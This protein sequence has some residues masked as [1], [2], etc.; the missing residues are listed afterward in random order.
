M[1]LINN[2]KKRLS[3]SHFCDN[4]SLNYVIDYLSYLIHRSYNYNESCV[5]KINF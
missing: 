5:I 2:Y 3:K 1:I 4:D